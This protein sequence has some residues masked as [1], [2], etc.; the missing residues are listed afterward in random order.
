MRR[1]YSEKQIKSMISSQIKGLEVVAQ[2]LVF[3]DGEIDL[4]DIE[5]EDGLYLFTYGN[6]YCF[7]P[8][9]QTAIEYTKVGAS[10]KTPMPCIYDPLGSFL[11]GTLVLYWNDKLILTIPSSGAEPYFPQDGLKLSIY[12]TKLF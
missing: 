6:C 4:E 7:L 2:N 10:I 1:M 11:P 12:K 8:I 3:Q 5:F 9:T